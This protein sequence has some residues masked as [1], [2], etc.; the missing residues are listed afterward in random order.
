MIFFMAM[1]FVIGLM[2]FVGATAARHSRRRLPDA[3]L[4]QLLADR[5]RTRC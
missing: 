2:N 1:P 5:D 4:R 3:Q